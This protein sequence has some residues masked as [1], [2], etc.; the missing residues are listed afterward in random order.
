MLA[1]AGG[2]VGL[3]TG[4]AR[5]ATVT[6]SSPAVLTSEAGV[7]PSALSSDVASTS[8]LPFI[9]STN[10]VNGSDSSS[11]AYGLSNAGFQISF[12]QAR[13]GNFAHWTKS[14]GS[15][16]FS[17]DTNVDF[18]A[19]GTF[20]GIHADPQTLAFAAGL[21]D[22]TT[23]TMVFL[24]QQQS[25][26]QLNETFTLGLAEGDALNAFVGALAGTL[27][28]GH[29]YLFQYEAQ[30]ANIN[31]LTG[32]PVSAHGSVSLSFV[33]EPSTALLL[34]M[35]LAALARR[36]ARRVRQRS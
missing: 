3:S 22:L 12:E 28:A 20:T 9:D 4:V 25:N 32:A 5:A 21:A 13:S 7:A 26:N 17:V 8:S 35:G 2:M 15:V 10:I 34:G 29:Q 14:S 36:G 23:G 33:P 18:L 11:A 6:L 27:L 24:S 30:S 31:T 19:A 1:F 16:Y